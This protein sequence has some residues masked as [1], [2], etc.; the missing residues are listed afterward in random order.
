MKKTLNNNPNYV[1]F[2]A[3]MFIVGGGVCLHFEYAADSE[4]D[5]AA[6]EDGYEDADYATEE[7]DVP[8]SERGAGSG[9]VPRFLLWAGWILIALG[10]VGIV[11]SFLLRQGKDF[12]EEKPFK[13]I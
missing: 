2:I 11:R 8:E 5:V 12:I 4:M 13:H 9:D 1:L 10:C 7:T 6:T 3:L